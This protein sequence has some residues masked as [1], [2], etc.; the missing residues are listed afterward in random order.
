MNVKRR[1]DLRVE[2]VSECIAFDLDLLQK[3]ASLFAPNQEYE[4]NVEGFDL[5]IEDIKSI[6]LYS[7]DGVQKLI[8]VGNAMAEVLDEYWEELSPD[9]RQPFED[10]AYNLIKLDALPI[11]L[12]LRASLAWAS[13]RYGKN[14]FKL[15]RAMLCR[16][17]DTLLRKIAAE[18][19][20]TLSDS[21]MTTVYLKNGGVEQVRL[22]DVTEYLESN[23]DKVESRKIQRRGPRRT[24]LLS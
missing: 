23:H 9:A 8:L 13:L 6:N 20:N 24:E 2:V 14:F 11:S 17:A 10:F 3:A 15:Y 7:A 19:P 12:K 22:G 4:S 16:L 18:P 5:T 1:S 21:V